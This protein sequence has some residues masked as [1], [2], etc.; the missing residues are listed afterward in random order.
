M[1]VNSKR[2]KSRDYAPRTE[3]EKAF[4]KSVKDS[5]ER[6]FKPEP[7]PIVE[8]RRLSAGQELDQRRQF[9]K[10]VDGFLSRG[11]FAAFWDLYS[12]HGI[13]HDTSVMRLTWWKMRDMEFARVPRGEEI[14]EK[15][16]NQDGREW[17]SN[18]LQKC[19]KNLE[20]CASIITALRLTIAFVPTPGEQVFPLQ[21]P[22]RYDLLLKEVPKLAEDLHRVAL[23]ITGLPSTRHGPRLEFE[24]WHRAISLCGILKGYSGSPLYE[25]AFRILTCA[26][27]QEFTSAEKTTAVKT[28]QRALRERGDK[29]LPLTSVPAKVKR[30]VRAKRK[31]RKH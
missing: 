12:R 1:G 3:E 13:P 16:Q 6:A 22:P 23:W 27:P 14:K 17:T 29:E 4:F 19:A 15:L 5:F 24:K 8:A 10:W 9:S 7:L 30:A 28:I 20:E 26:F 21:L 11:G 25:Y 2:K 18:K 31:Q